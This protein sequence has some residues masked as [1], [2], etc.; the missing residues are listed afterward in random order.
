MKIE[1]K[2]LERE[3]R[4]KSLYERLTNMPQADGK[5]VYGQMDLVQYDAVESSEKRDQEVKNAFK[6]KNKEVREFVK[7]QDKATGVTDE[8]YKSERRLFL[9]EDLFDD[10]KESDTVKL[11]EGKSSLK[12]A[13]EKKIE[14]V[15]AYNGA[16]VPISAH[17]FLHFRGKCNEA[18]FYRDLKKA[19]SAEQFRKIAIADTG[20]NWDIFEEDS[21]GV[22][23]V[24]NEPS[25]EKAY[26]RGLYERGASQSNMRVLKQILV[27]NGIPQDRVDEV[28]EDILTSLGTF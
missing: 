26:V 23:I 21:K 16:S 4:M 6:D 11:K 27:S 5:K 18:E 14:K 25:I 12:E 10:P 19:T 3:K 8:E 17:N 1:D 15:F 9:D 2:R 7:A 20:L 28:V 13:V 22:T 24:L